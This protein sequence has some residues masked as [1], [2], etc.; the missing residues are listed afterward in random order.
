MKKKI[1]DFYNKKNNNINQI[2]KFIFVGIL[3]TIVGYGTYVLFIFLSL[4]YLLAMLLGN[5]LGITHSYFWNKYF[6][7]NS[8]NKSLKELIRFIT[9]YVFILIINGVFLTIFIEFFKINNLIAGLL[10]IIIITFISF[11]GHKF[12]SFKV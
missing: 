9:V 6:T 3:N 10:T 7:F 5:I 4:H 8:K 1:L 12:Y 11:F 2:M